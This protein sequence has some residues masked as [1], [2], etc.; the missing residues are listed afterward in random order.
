MKKH[1]LSLATII[2]VATQSTAQLLIDTLAIQDFETVPS[3]PTWSYTGTLADLQT[4]NAP[5]GSCIPNTPLGIN[6]STAWHVA[7]VSGGNPIVFDNQTI[8]ANYDSIFVSFRVQGLNLNG[9]AGGPDHLD[10]VLVEYSL[11]GGVTYSPRVRV[12]GAVNN[13]SFWSYDAAGQAIVDYLPATE[14]VFQPANSGL[15]MTEGISFVQIGFPGSISQLAVRITPR[16][17]TSTDSWLVDNVLLTGHQ[18]CSNTVSSLTASSCGSYTSPSGNLYTTSGVYTDTIPNSTGCDSLITIDLTVNNSTYHTITTNS[19]DTYLSPA[20]NLYSATGVYYDTLTNASGCDSIITIDLTINTVNTNVLN[21]DPQL[22]ADA[23][24]GTY[25]WLDCDNGFAPISGATNQS[26]TATANGNYAVEITLNGC[27]DTSACN[28]V[29]T[30]GVEEQDLTNLSVYPN[31]TSDYVTINLG[32]KYSSIEVT[33]INALSQELSTTELKNAS[34]IKLPIEG[35]RGVYFCRLTA[36]G[37][38][39]TIRVIKE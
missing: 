16:S 37:N 39:T 13:N 12:R 22:T 7:S 30:V 6:S 33:L 27:T 34:S 23:F 10:Y 5:A 31:P 1:L 18:T 26:F 36:D 3:T 17:S 20:G 2:F 29:M 24:G 21:F 8:P 38:S 35:R 32:T 4:G 28:A 14:T 11:D 19:C 15:Q 9:S 25:Q